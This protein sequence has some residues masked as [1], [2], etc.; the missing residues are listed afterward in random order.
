MTNPPLTS[1]FPPRGSR[2]HTMGNPH[3]RAPLAGGNVYNPHY[4]FP[5]GMVPIQPLMNQLGG[6]YYH[7]R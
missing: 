4:N 5:I 7:T 3:P 6:G 1:I 2:S